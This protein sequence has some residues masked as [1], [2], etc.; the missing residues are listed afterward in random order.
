MIVISDGDLMASY[1]S[2]TTGNIFPLGYDR[3]TKETF[4]NKNF[5]LSV[6]TSSAMTPT[7]LPFVQK[8]LKYECLTRISLM[9]VN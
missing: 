1:V 7:C 8:S 6:L 4:G 3:F 5:M 2:K 9:Q